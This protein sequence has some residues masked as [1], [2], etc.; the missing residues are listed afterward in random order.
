MGVIIFVSGEMH[1]VV[2][3][4]SAQDGGLPQL[5]AIHKQDNAAILDA[6]KQRMG[7]SLAI[8]SEDGKCV[9]LDASPDLR[10]QHFQIL[11]NVPEYAEAR[12][13]DPS[14]ALFQGIVLTHAHM[15]HY[16]GL[17]HLGKESANTK[18]I[19]TYVTPKMAHFLR[20]NAPWNQLVSLNNIKLVEI[21][22]QPY[23]N[24]K[25]ISLWEGLSL[26]LF[27]IPHRAEYTCNLFYH[28]FYT[29]IK[30][31]LRYNWD[32]Y[33]FKGTLYS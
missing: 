15:G 4:G 20:T 19:P 7:A 29:I 9:L 17:A 30:N 27:T 13:K 21:D 2:V 25:D 11:M 16:L 18:S 14:M 6:E 5:G 10:Y 33:K 12:Q 22:P 28:F 32:F 8:V 26:K 23:V 3:L 24:A 31:L 1:K